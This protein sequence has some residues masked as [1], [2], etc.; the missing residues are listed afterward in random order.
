MPKKTFLYLVFLFV[1]LSNTNICFADVTVYEDAEDG[2][3]AG[4]DVYSGDPAGVTVTNVYDEERQSRVIDLYRDSSQG[5]RLRK[6]DLSPWSNTDQFVLSWRMKFGEYFILYIDLDT[7]AGHR[8][9]KY[10]PG[11]NSELGTDEYVH[12]GLEPYLEDGQWHPVVRNLLADLR[13]AQPEVDILAVNS[14]LIRGSGRLDDLRLMHTHWDGDGDGLTDFD[15]VN[16]YGSDPD[17]ADTDGDGNNDGDEVTVYGTS[18]VVADTD[19]D[20]MADGEELS[21]WGVN[22]DVDYDSDGLNNLVDVDADNDGVPDGAEVSQG[23]DPT[24][25]LSAPPT[26]YED[27]EDDLVLGWDVYDGVAAGTSITNV[28]DTERQS[29]VIDLFRDSLQGF[30]LRREDLSPWGNTGQFVLGWRMKFGEY[31]ILY[32]KLNTTAGPRYLKYTPADN[33]G[34][35]TDVYVHHGLAPYLE[36]GQWHPVVRDLLADLQQAQP[37]VDILEVN[38]FFIRGSGRLDHVR[39]LHKDWDGDGDGL[40]DFDEVNTYGSDPDVADTDGDGINDGDEATVYGTSPV[41]TD[42]DADGMA[43]GEEQSYW[44]ANWDVDYDSDGLNNLVDVDADNDG[45]PDGVEVSQGF[46]PIDPLS[47]P[48]TIYE[49]AQDSLVLGWDV[50]DGVAAGTSITNVFDAERQSRVID[51]FRDNSQGFRLRKGDLSPWGNTG[52]FV[53]GW[54]MKFGKYFILYIDLNTT[55]GHRYLKY[56]PGDNNELGTGEYVHHGL[57]AYLEDGQWHPVVRDLL[58]D[59]QEAQP[60]V[61]ILAVNGF[62]IR[63]SGRLDDIR[64][65]HKSWDGD[66]DGVTDWDE[67][68]TYDTDPDVVDPDFISFVLDHNQIDENL[69]NF[70]V[71]LN[72]SDYSGTNDFDA[73]K[74]LSALMPDVNADDDFTGSD[75]DLPNPAL[76]SI[77]GYPDHTRIQSGKLNIRSDS[78]DTWNTIHSRETFWLRGDFD[79]QVDFEVVSGPETSRW[80]GFLA[81]YNQAGHYTRFER[82]YNDAQGGHGY[83]HFGYDGTNYPMEG[84]I[85]RNDTSG[86]LKLTRSGATFKSYAW[87]NDQWNLVATSSGFNTGEDVYLQIGVAVGTDKP[88]AEINFDNFQVNSGNLGSFKHRKNFA[89]YDDKGRQCY[90]EIQKWD[91]FNKKALLWVSVPEVSATKDTRLKIYFDKNMEVQETRPVEIASDQFVLENGSAPTPEL[92]WFDGQPTVQEGKLHLLSTGPIQ[93]IISR[94]YIK[95]DFDIQYDFDLVQDPAVKR[96]NLVLRATSRDGKIVRVYYRYHNNYEYIFNSYNGTSWMTSGTLSRRDTS[97]KLRLSRIGDVFY[98]FYWDADNGWVEV[99]NTSGTGVKNTSDYRVDLYLDSVEN[100]PTAEALVD[101]FTVNSGTV[102]GFAGDTGETP[103]WAVWDGNY[104]AVFHFEQKSG[105]LIDSTSRKNNGTCDRFTVSERW[106][107]SPAGNAFY[108]SDW[109]KIVL[110]DND[111]FKPNYANIE[112]LVKISPDN[113]DWARIFDRY[114]HPGTGYNLCITN[115]GK[116]RFEERVT[117]GVHGFADS[118]AAVEGDGKWHYV[119]GG[120]QEGHT[121]LYNDGILNQDR[122]IVNEVIAHYA[123]QDPMIG[124]GHYEPNLGFKGYIS[125]IRF[126][127]TERSS[128]WLKATHHTLFDA[129]NLYTDDYDNDGIKDADEVSLYGT[130]PDSADTDNDGINDGDELF[131]YGDQWLQDADSDGTINLLDDDSDN[132]LLLDGVE[133]ITYGSNPVS[134]DSDGDQIA[135]GDEVNTFLTNPVSFDTDR[136]GLHDNAELAYWGANWS[137]DYD[138]DGLNNLQ[139]ADA[140]NDGVTDKQESDLGFDPSDSGSTPLVQTADVD[141]DLGMAV[142]EQQGGGGLV[143][144][145]IRILNGNV[146]ESRTDLSFPS[147]NSSGLDFEAFYNSRSIVAGALGYG[148]TH[149]YEA[150]FSTGYD[151]DGQNAVKVIGPTGRARFFADTG[152]DNFTGL[153]NEKSY[154]KSESGE[155]VWYRL[156]GSR[157]GFSAEGK[158]SWIEDEIGNRLNV[159]YNAQG[160]I[161]TVTDSAGNRVLTFHYDLGLLDHIAGPVTAAVAGGIWVSFGYD[162]NQNLTSVTYADGSGLNYSYTDPQDIHNLTAKRNQA[163]H[164]IS[165]WAYNDQDLC[166]NNFSRDGTGVGI[167]YTNPTQVDVT[168][169]YGTQRTYTI[170]NIS[171]RKRVTSMQGLAGAP[172]DKSNLVRWDYD[173]QMNLDEVETT[174]GTIHQYQ[175]HDGRGNPGSVI[176]AS[177]SAPPLQRTITYTYHPGMNVPLTRS[178]PS[179]LGAGNKVTIWDYDNDGNTTANENPTGKVYRIIEQGFTRDSSGA[180]VPY[181]YTTIF[182]YNTKGQITSIDGPRTGT[183][184][185]TV[186][187]YDPVTGDLDSTTQPLIGTTSFNNYDAAGQPGSITDINGQIESFAYDGRGRLKSVTHA[188]DSSARSVFYNNAGLPEITTDEDGVSF[189]FEY[190]DV[191][192]RLERKVD[193]TGNYVFYQ[194]DDQGNLKEK[195][196]H[197]PADTRTSRK[198]WSYQHP[199]IPGKLWKEIKADD[200]YSEYGYDDEGNIESITNFKS[201]ITSYAYDAFNRLHTVTQPGGLL[202][203]YHYDLHGNLGSVTDAE[204]HATTFTYDDMGRLVS[205]TSPDTGTTVYVYDEAG[206]A[207]QKTDAKGI[208]STYVYDA[209]NRLTN[210]HFPDANEDITYSFDQG[211]NAKGRLSGITDSSGNTVFGFDDRGRLDSKTSTVSGIDF[212]I[213]RVY[214]PGSRVSTFA[215]PSG[216]TMEFD[217]YKTTGRPRKITTTYGSTVAVLMNNLVYNPFGSPKGMDSGS[218]SS[219]DNR[220]DENNFLKSVNPGEMLEQTYSYDPNGNLTGIQ[221]P[222]T[223]WFNQGFTYDALNRLETA[224]GIYGSMIYTYD[225]VGNRKTRT[226][227]DATDTYIY[228]PGTNKL[229]E[230][231][232]TTPV[233][234]AYDD[235]GNTTGYGSKTLVYNQNNRL[236]R[237]EDGATILG[238]YTYNALGQRISK[239]VNGVVTIFHYDFDGNIIAES[240]SDGV[241]KKEYLYVGTKRLAMVEVDSNILYHYQN[242]NL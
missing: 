29:R 80:H 127:N 203:T 84:T 209:L 168:D 3:T 13:E 166:I 21:Y 2:L 111:D 207:V 39:L 16:T 206:N 179:V 60:G 106:K 152:G 150:S 12:H 170:S 51:L 223:P 72:L 197:D 172:Y 32:I 202:T 128:A 211:E 28:F 86:K 26:I 70:P 204:T 10:T 93:R 164:L 135:D 23:F 76:W 107:S 213:S 222:N 78:S 237:V 42:T 40:S 73:S 173:A 155:Y 44:G 98:G 30:R 192:G 235:N 69:T 36:D 89:V 62:L 94:W 96:W 65:M 100:K 1:F 55:A 129:L 184:D 201:Q 6:E 224:T 188:A 4:W 205:T 200:S 199:T 218:G 59:L 61:D 136:D 103:A 104:K 149:S 71:L 196:V 162:G 139:D 53:L 74:Q 113:P 105:Y 220:S 82:Q 233:T 138:G 7:T 114:N 24:D 143:G 208:T 17:V 75:G 91:P 119:S 178:E 88:A 124:L 52:Q 121:R 148:W 58:A 158:L 177:G 102:T 159:V 193:A 25:P 18:P 141:V 33:S 151:I 56:T 226:V 92:W 122:S 157:Y 140:D 90:A 126:S 228:Q 63:G 146:V 125:E 123:W 210:V 118:N 116:F 239:D 190:D 54:R 22:W 142:D 189:S 14:F 131:Y 67:V 137:T 120:Y 147:P 95:G 112:A 175:N 174:G 108:F 48:P 171:S 241:F 43:D 176:L 167:F 19:A 132:D 77:N 160:R 37:G 212:T 66:G 229:S 227:D 186:L 115:E 236:I 145:T 225:N 181:E 156:D 169:A 182:K 27:A 130:D 180:T 234:F 194:Y 215:Y 41:V 216:R 217:R 153:W 15:E 99:G 161:E 187:A 240:G 232:G 238:E 191:N 20:G 195:S 117:G 231:T 185:T 79:I 85:N 47:V 64:L 109:E 110:P 87:Y 154:V 46:D 219:V 83:R 81:I 144:E 34:L 97:G 230:I 31:F 9:L 50:Y 101:N 45:V 242:N 38:G 35:G 8:Y 214:S 68:N 134:T 11:D 133:I 221:A 163:N 57:A 165:T 198:R 49:D 183:E 5:F